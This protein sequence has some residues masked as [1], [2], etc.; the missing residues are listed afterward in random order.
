MSYCTKCGAE[1]PENSA[2]CSACGNPMGASYA[3]VEQSQRGNGRLRKKLHCPECKGQNLSASVEMMGHTGGAYR[4]TNRLSVGSSTAINQTNWICG[5]CGL[6]FR[7]IQDLEK[8]T[9]Q[10]RRC[11]RS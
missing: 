5:D 11:I 10:A 7:N 8:D 4:M 9:K 3:P 2:F 1:V 6:K